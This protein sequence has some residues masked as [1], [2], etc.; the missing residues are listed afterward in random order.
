MSSMPE[1]QTDTSTAVATD[2]DAGIPPG[3][4]S[5]SVRTRTRACQVSDT[6][7]ETRMPG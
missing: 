3:I 4:G 1:P 5:H 2:V 6:Q 7:S